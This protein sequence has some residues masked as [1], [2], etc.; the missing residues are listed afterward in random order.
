L[1]LGSRTSS[2]ANIS[3]SGGI[4]GTGG[5]IYKDFGSTL[6]LTGQ[7]SYTG[8]T[9]V[10]EG[11]LRLNRTGGN[12]IPAG[13]SI[14]VNAGA[15]LRIST[16][17]T[18]A[19]LTINT[20]GTLI[21]DDGV[22]LTVTGTSTYSGSVIVRSAT[23]SSATTL[24]NL[25]ID[26]ASGVSLNSNLTIAGNLTLT[27]GKLSLGN[28]NLTLSGTTSGGSSSS[29]IATTGSGAVIVNSIGASSKTFPVGN[30]TYNPVS[31]ANGSNHNWSVRV[32]DAINNLQSGFTNSK[33]VLRTWH[34]APSTNPPS[35]GANITFQYDDADN[36]QIGGSFSTSENM[37]LWHYG[38]SWRL[39]SGDITPTG[40]AGGTRT[41]TINGLTQFSPYAL[42]NITGPLP[43]TFTSLTG[44]IRNGQ[45]QLNW[46]IADE[47]NVDHYQV[48]ESNSG[49]HF[50]NLAQVDASN[51]S[52]YQASD[53][54]LNTG[55]N[56]YRVKAVD[57]D[58]KLTYSKIIRLENGS[59]DQQIRVYPN[60]SQGEL[61]LGLNIAAGS[62]QIRV[63]NAVGQTVYQQPLT[64][65]GGSRSLPLALPKLNA[66][67][68]QVEVRGGMQKYVRSVRIE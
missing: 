46:T 54:A 38:S 61:T 63:I 2:L 32:E 67:I 5:S 55:A 21:V 59:V 24:N 33:A 62:Y 37:Q 19:N 66:G 44:S 1:Y 60:P 39:A 68:Y 7:N 30:S 35:A 48:E 14:T 31:I 8:N 3:I 64:H 11:T 18:L 58:G 26:R 56:F 12:T 57:I 29:Y 52:A 47:H 10:A 15:T 22:N 25:E 42:A 65:E 49:I 13:N 28:N 34:I 27:S 9:T 36:T 45:A 43:V 51:R 40:S 17:Q 23:F 4:S 16:D 6:T 53:A 50:R 20:S 41:V